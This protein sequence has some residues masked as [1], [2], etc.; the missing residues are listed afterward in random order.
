ML[1]HCNDFMAFLYFRQFQNNGQNTQKFKRDFASRRC[2]YKMY[3][4]G[5]GSHHHHQFIW[6]KPNTNAKAM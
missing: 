3:T 4:A 2:D 6:I 1:M 5:C